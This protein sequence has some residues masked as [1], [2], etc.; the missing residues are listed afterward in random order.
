MNKKVLYCFVVFCVFLCCVGVYFF[1]DGKEVDDRKKEVD[2]SKEIEN[3]IEEMLDN[4]SLE[5]KIGQMLIVNFNFDTA[6]EDLVNYFEK[7]KPGGIILMKPN[8][9]NFENTKK[10]V[11]DI[12]KL[13][14]IPL[15]VSVDQEGGRVQRLQYLSDGNPIFVPDMLSLGKLNDSNLTYEVGKVIAEEVRTI[16]VNVDFAPV[17]DI[18]SNL[19][20]KVIGDRSFGHD[21]NTVGTLALSLAK[22][23]K[24][25]G[26]IPVFK[27]FPGH[28]DT[29]T[30]SHVKLPIIYKTYEE[31]ESLELIPFKKSIESGADIIMTAHIALPNITGDNTPA[32][33][34]KVIIT[35]ILKEKLN[36]KG[37]VITDALNMKSLTNYYS[38]EEI[39]LKSIEAGNDILLMPV[40]AKNAI[41]V[42]K[43]NI[44]EERINES[45]R[46]I[47]VFKYKYLSE[48]NLLDASY[49]GDEE[50]KKIIDK[51][52]VD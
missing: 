50:H 11:Q 31:L 20:N 29:A 26:V 13:F 6:S 8:F 51:I 36:F 52:K 34:S 7:V 40:D 41:Q 43:E 4:M 5:E 12:K 16:G 38:N 14:D 17:L 28:G 2:K 9:T 30:D 42:I 3:K 22:G 49:L 10:L 1:G 18:Y 21:A 19:D 47:L 24:D 48:D 27:H 32:T 37:I 25:N 39:I 46:K 35:D 23:L 15:I 33:L 44:S 45:V